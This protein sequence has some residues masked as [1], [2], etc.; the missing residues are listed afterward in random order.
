[1]IDGPVI[2]GPVIEEEEEEEEGLMSGSEAGAAGRM[3]SWVGSVTPVRDT[4]Q[5]PQKRCFGCTST[6]HRWQNMV[7]MLSGSEHQLS[8]GFVRT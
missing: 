8:V 3:S 4:P 5:S 6:P 1:V 7:R 2:E